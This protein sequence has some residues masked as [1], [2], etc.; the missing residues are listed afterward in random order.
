M[1]VNFRFVLML[2]GL[3]L[4]MGACSDDEESGGGDPIGDGISSPDCPENSFGHHGECLCNDGYL[5]EGEHPHLVCVSR[6]DKADVMVSSAQ[7]V[8]LLHTHCI[9]AA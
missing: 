5:S 3:T 6:L 8:Y 1:P 2:F 4:A 7:A 9:S